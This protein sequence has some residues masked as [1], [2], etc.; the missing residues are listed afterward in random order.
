[1][2]L[3]GGLIIKHERNLQMNLKRIIINYLRF[4]KKE[5]TRYFVVGLSGTILDLATLFVFKTYFD[6]SAVLAVVFNQLLMIQYIFFMNKF[7]S[8]GAQ[9]QTSRQMIKFYA[10]YGVNYIIAVAWMWAFHD[11][12][13]AQYLLVRLGNIAASTLWNFLLY[14]YWVFA[15]S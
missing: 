8:F 13:G 12:L 15:H 1:M 10:L 2:L 5:L 4:H 9:G 3:L 11:L 6:M 14:K 7:W